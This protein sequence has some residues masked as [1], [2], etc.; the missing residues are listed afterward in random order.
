MEVVVQIEAEADAY[1]DPEEAEPHERGPAICARRPG[2]GC[3]KV[4]PLCPP[5]QAVNGE[6]CIAEMNLFL[7]VELAEV[8]RVGAGVEGNDAA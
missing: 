5:C 4:H 2:R 3:M 7:H 1:E 8:N 6:G